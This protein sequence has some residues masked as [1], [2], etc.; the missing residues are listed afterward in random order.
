MK[1]LA[2]LFSGD[3][4]VISLYGAG[5]FVG[6]QPMAEIGDVGCPTRKGMRPL[7]RVHSHTQPIWHL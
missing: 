4:V 3:S 2:E 6:P 1:R 5:I 7:S